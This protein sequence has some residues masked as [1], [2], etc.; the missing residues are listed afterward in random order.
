MVL[1]IRIWLY[2][3]GMRVVNKWTQRGLFDICN[4]IFL[5]L[6]TDQIM[7]INGAAHLQ[8]VYLYV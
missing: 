3:G 4:I 1:E 2:L 8:L 5:T 6:G 7:V